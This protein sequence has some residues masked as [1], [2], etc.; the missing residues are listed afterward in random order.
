MT[1]D[2]RT[3]MLLYIVLGGLGLILLDRVIIS[4][5]WN[6]WNQLG[7]DLERVERDL[8]SARATVAREKAVR[9][10]WERIQKRLQTPREPDVQTH[11]VSHL[12]NMWERAGVGFDVHTGPQQQ[13][14]D[15]R[16]YVYETKFKLKWEE[17]VRLLVELDNSREFLR[18]IRIG[19]HSRYDREDRLDVD[20]RV[21][22]IEYSPELTKKG[23]K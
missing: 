8:R 5:W 18:P 2:R 4:P 9:D 13:Q 11:F 23:S 16:E 17:L 10:D 14:G 1:M 20:L 19:V 15:F 21:S 7:T 3:R 6:Q 12:G 22:T